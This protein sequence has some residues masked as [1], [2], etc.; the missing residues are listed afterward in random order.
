MT[1]LIGSLFCHNAYAQQEVVDAINEYGRFDKWSRREIDESGIIGG[2]KKYLYEFYGDYGTTY[3]GETPYS[4]PEGYIWRTNNVLA[5]VMGIVKTNNTVF[6]EERG[7][8]YCA[9]IETKIEEV[10]ALGVID[11]D[12]TCQG[13]MFIGELPEP[14]TGTKDPM[15]KVYYGVPF[16]GFPKGLKLDIKADVGHEVVRAT[17]FSKRKNM[18]YPDWAEITVILQ[19]RWEDED[20]NIHAQRVGTG[21]ERIM[22]DIP[23]WKNGHVIPIRYGDITGR[24]YYQS[25]MGLKTDPETAYRAVNSKGKTVIVQEDEWAKPGT[26]PN[27]LIISIISSCNKAF[28]GGIGNKVWIDNVELLMK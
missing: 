17:G 12:V 22:E 27:H 16:T 18:G 1:L 9:R 19:Y 20:G 24:P 6:P 7:Y 15:S 8:G 14:I 4:A 23:E 10:K 5:V 2:N 11:M 3:T 28:H 21:I 13:A 25:Y 26:K